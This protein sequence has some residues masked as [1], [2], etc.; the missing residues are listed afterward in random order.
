MVW[1]LLIPVLSYIILCNVEDRSIQTLRTTFRQFPAVSPSDLVRPKATST[2]ILTLLRV[3]IVDPRPVR[4]GS[5]E[6]TAPLSI[7]AS[8]KLALIQQDVV[9]R[10]NLSFIELRQTHAWTS[11]LWWDGGFWRFITRNVP[12]LYHSFSYSTRFHVSLTSSIVY[13]SYQIINHL[14]I[15]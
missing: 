14:Q 3:I 10:R 11:S 6:L 1:T 5:F 4:T 7:R 13:T 15:A 12:A 9:G 2:A 8:P